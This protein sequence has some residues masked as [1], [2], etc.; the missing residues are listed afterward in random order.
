[1]LK[2]KIK[3]QPNLGSFI[4]VHI[5][6]IFMYTGIYNINKTHLGVLERKTMNIISNE[7]IKLVLVKV[8]NAIGSQVKCNMTIRP[9]KNWFD[10]SN[11]KKM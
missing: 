5:F 11:I 1:M 10:W 9:K 7:A 6:P 8:P 4:H 2:N 3:I